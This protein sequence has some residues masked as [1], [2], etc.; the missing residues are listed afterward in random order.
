MSEEH[1]YNIVCG[2]IV[3]AGFIVI[4]CYFIFK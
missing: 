2:A 1:I 4:I 3:I